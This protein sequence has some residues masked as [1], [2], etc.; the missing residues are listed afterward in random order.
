MLSSPTC[1]YLLTRMISKRELA[2]VVSGDFLRLCKSCC[3]S[4]PASW[5]PLVL[6]CSSCF[7][8]A[9]TGLLQHPSFPS[10]SSFTL[11]SVYGVLMLWYRCQKGVG[12]D[13]QGLLCGF[14][15]DTH[16]SQ[17]NES[18]PWPHLLGMGIDGM[19]LIA[20]ILSLPFSCFHLATYL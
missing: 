19:K 18:G 6:F 13:G 1:S 7:P 9:L 3:L 11:S 15:L 17:P 10:P 12:P 20:G 8:W 4:S 16:C 14:V 5:Y 2:Q